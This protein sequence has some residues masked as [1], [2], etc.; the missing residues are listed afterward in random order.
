VICCNV[1]LKI[2]GQ[3]SLTWHQNT[4]NTGVSVLSQPVDRG[5]GWK[6]KEREGERAQNFQLLSQHTTQQ[7][8]LH[9]M[10]VHGFMWGTSY[11]ERL[12][13]VSWNQISFLNIAECE[14]YHVP[15]ESTSL[16]KAVFLYVLCHIVCESKLSYNGCKWSSSVAFWA[17]SA[18]ILICFP[19]QANNFPGGLQSCI[20]YV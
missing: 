19:S 3:E 1:L 15:N 8:W 4:C 5:G 14:V 16:Q 20:S 7:P 18:D 2:N 11:L 17:V 6:E 12:Y 13:P 10:T 9:V